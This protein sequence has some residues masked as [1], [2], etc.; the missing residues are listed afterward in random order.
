MTDAPS[1]TSKDLDRIRETG[2]LFWSTDWPNLL[3]LAA[4][5]LDA[6]AAVERV[7]SRDEPIPAFP[8][9]KGRRYLVQ[10]SDGNWYYLNH[11]STWQTCPPPHRDDVARALAK[12][13]V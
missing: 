1:F 5:G 11:A 3:A 4:A 8:G 13:E 9:L 7:P 10:D 6:Q 2:I 12:K